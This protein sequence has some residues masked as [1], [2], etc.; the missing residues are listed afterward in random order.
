MWL[1]RAEAE[2]GPGYDRFAWLAHIRQIHGGSRSRI[3]EIP[4]LTPFPSY[5]DDTRLLDV[6]RGNTSRGP[7]CYS[8]AAAVSPSSSSSSSMAYAVTSMV[9]RPATYRWCIPRTDEGIVRQ[10]V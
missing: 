6:T 9:S 7:R 5:Q 2:V 4:P 8:V 3:V 1:R 10:I